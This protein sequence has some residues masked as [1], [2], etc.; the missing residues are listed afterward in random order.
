[1]G[2]EWRNLTARIQAL[3]WGIR[4]TPTERQRATTAA[5][6]VAGRLLHH[7]SDNYALPVSNV[8]NAHVIGGFGK[9]TARRGNSVV[10]LL[11]ALPDHLR[12]CSDPEL[13]NAVTSTRDLFETIACVLAHHYQGV[14][15]TRDGWL[16]LAMPTPQTLSVR[17]RP[18][19]A[20]QSGGYLVAQPFARSGASPW[21]HS[22]PEAERRLLDDTDVNSGG[23]ATDLILMLKLWRHHH[24]VPIS[25]FAIEC[26]AV[27]FVQ[28]WIYRG[29]SALFYDWMMRDFFFWMVAQA[30]R[31]LT[32]PGSHELVSLGD[33]WVEHAERAYFSAAQGSDFE[34]DNRDDRALTCWRQVFGP[35]YGVTPF[36][37]DN[38]L[39]Q[40]RVLATVQ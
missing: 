2:I 14:H 5:T 35:S 36:L 20:C 17:L 16:G 6:Q 28:S 7:L 32:I 12:P 10:D 19:F 3:L 1:M 24:D 37:A 38:T 27:E 23:K 8:G 26:L 4:A 30:G 25:S 29:Q 33:D 34:R 21:R 18:S 13:A 11:V 40:N 15:I 22:H 31:H 39:E 9:G